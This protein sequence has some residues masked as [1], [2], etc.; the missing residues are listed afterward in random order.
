MIPKE[1]FGAIAAV[2]GVCWVFG[3]VCDRLVIEW[4]QSQAETEDD[5]DHDR[6]EDDPEPTCES[7]E[8]PAEERLCVTCKCRKFSFMHEPCL[9]CGLERKNW[10]AKE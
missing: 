1:A 10:E 5:P 7:A 4:I 3:I 8:N 9:S 2:M 6:W